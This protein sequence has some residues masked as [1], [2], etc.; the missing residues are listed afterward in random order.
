MAK[1][2]LYGII[3]EYLKIKIDN[4]QSLSNL[5]L[6]DKFVSKKQKCWTSMLVQSNETLN[7]VYNTFYLGMNS[8]LTFKSSGETIAKSIKPY[9]PTAS[10]NKEEIYYVNSS[11]LDNQ[12]TEFKNILF[13][14]EESSL[15][16]DKMDYFAYCIEIQNEQLIILGKV[17]RINHFRSGFVMKL[18]SGNE[19]EISKNDKFGI[20]DQIGLIIYKDDIF[21][22]QKS[23]FENF[24][25]LE[26]KF[27]KEAIEHI[28][29]LN[30][31]G[32]FT[33]LDLYLEK[34]KNNK[35]ITRK[36]S[37]ALDDFR[38]NNDSFQKIDVEDFKKR[39]GVIMEHDPNIIL[40][41]NKI[42][43]DENTE[44]DS[45]TKLVTDDYFIRVMTERFGSSE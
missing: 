19:I 44:M 37:K 4:V 6:I 31:S 28:A 32:Y 45:I 27:K 34:V 1:D 13:A 11:Y 8:N 25:D 35:S 20:N 10:D 42:I 24:F 30:K 22:F 14:K 5:Y 17:N 38:K 16:I 3:D 9:S 33:G 40:K 2:E 23:F 7:R 21:I 41:G 15:T 36:I 39:V 26:E 18:I 29:D 12:V 43:I